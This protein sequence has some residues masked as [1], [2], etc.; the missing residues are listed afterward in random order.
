MS[1]V[2][3][4]AGETHGAALAALAADLGRDAVREAGAGDRVDG[5]AP[6]AVVRPGDVDGVR[7]AV[8]IAAAHGIALVASG[9]GRHLA[10]G[11]APARCGILLRLD[12][13]DRVV[14]HHAADMTVTVEAGCTLASLAARLHEAG[15]WLPLDPPDPAETTVGG[16]VAANLSGPLRASQGTA[17]DLLLGIETVS[18]EGLVVRGG[19][20][21][22]KNVAGYDLPRLHVGALGSLGVVVGA[23]FKTRPRPAAERAIEVEAASPQEACDLALAIRDAFEPTWLELAATD[24]GPATRVLAGFAGIAEEAACG[25]EHGLRTAAERGR[26]AREVPD[27]TACRESLAAFPLQDAAAILRLSTLPDRSGAALAAL[28]RAARDCG[29]RAPLAAHVANGV[30]R[31]AI[32]DAV[33]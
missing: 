3:G 6:F 17:R 19:G 11:A 2:T 16:L 12:R 8:A 30:V 32:P 10:I 31:A 20:R 24:G 14:E 29:V 33:A 18:G 22:V 27:A 4:A 15:Q 21:V 25:V 13:L 26:A 5:A 7:R 23:T 9:R 28:A 1:A